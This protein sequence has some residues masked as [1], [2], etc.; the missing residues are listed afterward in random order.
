MSKAVDVITIDVNVSKLRRERFWKDKNGDLHANLEVVLMKK[1]SP[2]GHDFFVI[3]AETKEEWS[4][5]KDQRPPKV[6][7]GNGKSRDFGGGTQSQPVRTIQ[8]IQQEEEDSD[9]PF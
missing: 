6:F 9:L 7:V 3:E 8:E 2:Y 5:P 1:P 4:L